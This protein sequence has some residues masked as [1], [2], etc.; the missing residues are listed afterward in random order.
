MITDKI[1]LLTNRE[2]ACWNMAEVCL[3][4]RDAHGLLHMSVEIQGIQWALRELKA[5]HDGK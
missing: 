1:Q 5:V 3:L 2:T 4:C